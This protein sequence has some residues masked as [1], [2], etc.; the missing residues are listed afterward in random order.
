MKELDADSLRENLRV[1]VRKLGLLQREEAVCCGLTL[2]QC[3][4]IIEIGQA[5]KIA[6]IRLAESLNL[7][8]STVTR[9]VDTLEKAGLVFREPSPTDRRV[10]LAC[11]TAEGTERYKKINDGM[12]RY[13]SQIIAS[14]PALKRSSVAEGLEIFVE[15]LNPLPI[16]EEAKTCNERKTAADI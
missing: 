9:N 13:F 16:E 4:T 1:M 3:H 11:L 8:G 15:A 5:G 14:I 2:G 12:N 7:D 10:T 6:M